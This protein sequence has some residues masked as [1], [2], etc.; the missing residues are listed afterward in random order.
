MQ[1]IRRS[2]EAR[3]SRIAALAPL[4]ATLFVASG[5]RVAAES[6]PVAMHL[7][8]DVRLWVVF[9]SAAMVLSA[10]TA[11]TPGKRVLA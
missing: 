10:L 3:G 8:Y 1:L 4:V 6:G 5:R 9:L 2:L 11:A 7:L